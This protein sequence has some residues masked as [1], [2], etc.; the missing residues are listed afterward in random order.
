MPLT[1]PLEEPAAAPPSGEAVAKKGELDPGAVA[2][3]SLEG[4]GNRGLVVGE[5]L[6]GRGVG[7]E[8]VLGEKVEP[9]RV[10]DVPPPPLLG[11]PPSPPPKVPGD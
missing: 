2:V 11:V 1:L 3:G 8:R 9:P 10:V 6:A 5:K 4:V 7:V